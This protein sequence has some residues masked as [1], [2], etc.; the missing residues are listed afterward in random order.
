MKQNQENYVGK[1][2]SKWTVIEDLGRN[3]YNK[4][5][6]KCRCECGKEAEITFAQTKNNSFCHLPGVCYPADD[7]FLS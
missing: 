2:F 1:K 4:R 6:M 3:K 7:V 5:Y